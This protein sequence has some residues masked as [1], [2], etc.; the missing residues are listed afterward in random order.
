[1]ADLVFAHNH[2]KHAKR[3]KSRQK[4][5]QKLHSKQQI[6]SKQKKV[7]FMSKAAVKCKKSCREIQRQQWR[8]YKKKKKK[9]PPTT[10]C[11]D[12]YFTS[13]CQL[14]PIYDTQCTYDARWEPDEYCSDNQHGR[15]WSVCYCFDCCRWCDPDYDLY[16][17]VSSDDD[18]ISATLSDPKTLDGRLPPFSHECNSLPFDM[19]TLDGQC[20]FWWS[21]MRKLDIIE[22]LFWARYLS[23]LSLGLWEYPYHEDLVVDYFYHELGILH[24]EHLLHVLGELE[25]KVEAQFIA[26]YD[27]AAYVVLDRHSLIILLDTHNQH[28]LGVDVCR[29]IA[30]YVME[31][32]SVLSH[33]QRR[34]E[35]VKMRTSTK[36]YKVD[37][38]LGVDVCRLIATYVMEQDGVLSHCQRREECVN[39]RTSTKR[40]KVD[41]HQVIDEYNDDACIAKIYDGKD[42]TQQYRIAG[43]KCS[44]SNYW[45]STFDCILALSWSQFREYCLY[46]QRPPPIQYSVLYAIIWHYVQHVDLIKDVAVEVSAMD[47]Q[48]EFELLEGALSATAH[49]PLLQSLLRAI[50]KKMSIVWPQQRVAQ[51]SLTQTR[52]VCQQHRMLEFFKQCLLQRVKRNVSSVGNG[53]ISSV[54]RRVLGN[55]PW[56]QYRSSYACRNCTHSDGSDQKQFWLEIWKSM[57]ATADIEALA[58]LFCNH[59]TFG[60]PPLTDFVYRSTAQRLNVTDLSNEDMV[61]HDICILRSHL[62]NGKASFEEVLKLMQRISDGHKCMHELIEIERAT[63]ADRDVVCGA[64]DLEQHKMSKFHRRYVSKQKVSKRKALK[65][66]FRKY[67]GKKRDKRIEHKMRKYQPRYLC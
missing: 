64:L 48:W 25:A 22:E 23:K 21:V 46:W 6:E 61:Q 12:Y 38:R 16:R 66:R 60:F 11:N 33:C 1:M 55:D 35:F 15:P 2:S 3:I 13:E 17:S 67:D 65:T 26:D 31:Q 19:S 5:K 51:H 50:D 14:D 58:A 45:R 30:T 43:E 20:R 44:V 29:L 27:K 40:Y 37:G 9:K 62:G 28:D 56:R 39:M 36:R 57:P 24:P 49:D 34:E 7:Q 8:K 52:Y 18:D 10:L 53:E 42:M 41:G 47:K 54:M 63:E 4:Q 32:E 59:Q